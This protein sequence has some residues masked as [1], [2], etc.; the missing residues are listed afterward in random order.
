MI[1]PLPNPPPAPETVDLAHRFPVRTKAGT[2]LY[3]LSIHPTDPDV[4]FTSC[5]LWSSNFV[6][7]SALVH[8]ADL[9]AFLSYARS[10]P[11]P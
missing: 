9:E 6:L 5:H 4:I 7:L 10:K 11:A 2:K 8:D 1:A 3:A